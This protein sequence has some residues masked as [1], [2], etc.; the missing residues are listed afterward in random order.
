VKVLSCTAAVCRDS[1]YLH[2][3]SQRSLFAEITEFWFRTTSLSVSM[4][5]QALH[6]QNFAKHFPA[7]WRPYAAVCFGCGMWF[8]RTSPP[9]RIH[10]SANRIRS[11]EQGMRLVQQS[12][13]LRMLRSA[14]RRA[15][16][17]KCLLRRLD[18]KLDRRRIP[19][20]PF[21]P[22]AVRFRGASFF[23]Y[24]TEQYPKNNETF[25][26]HAGI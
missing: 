26:C 8:H 25:S 16:A 9:C 19:L 11:T 23:R 6:R 24:T 10:E 17:E 7:P 20:L 5:C 15:R 14:G 18:P 4:S 2:A 22:S 13:G 3:A 21:K 12:G 1:T